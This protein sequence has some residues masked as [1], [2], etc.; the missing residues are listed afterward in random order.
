MME[1]KIREYEADVHL[2]QEEAK[3][4]LKAWGKKFEVQTQVL[5]GPTRG[6]RFTVEVKNAETTE[7][8]VFEGTFEARDRKGG[9]PVL[10]EAGFS[11]IATKDGI[12]TPQP[13][14]DTAR[15]WEK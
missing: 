12:S 4:R 8:K 9:K 7:L 5:T 15:W 13:F 2:L 3:K 6:T 1:D 10:V 14:A 11:V